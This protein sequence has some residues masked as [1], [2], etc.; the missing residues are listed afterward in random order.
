MPDSRFDALRQQMVEQQIQRRG[1]DDPGVLSAM[2][3]VPRHL[4]VPESQRRDAYVDHP[5]P[6]GEGQT[7]SQP[8]IVA[9]MTSLLELDGSEKVLEIGTGSGYQA[10]V[11]AELADQVYTIEIREGLGLEAGELLESL[12]YDNL[13]VR[14]GNG[15][16]GW[17]EEAPF[18]AIIVTASPPEIPAALVEQLKIGGRM[19]VPIGAGSVQDLELLTKTDAGLERKD[20]VPVRFVPMIGGREE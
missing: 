1:V 9:L 17:P 3:R 15:Y 2:E 6:I 4:F 12:G 5:L 16:R 18:D 10:A 13:H 19:V 8:Y 14:I 7:I 11:L 20:I